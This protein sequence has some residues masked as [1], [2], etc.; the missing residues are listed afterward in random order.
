[1]SLSEGREK[2]KRSRIYAVTGVSLVVILLVTGV[3]ARNG[4]FPRTDPMTGERTGWFGAKLAKNTPSSW[5]PFAMPSP[6]PT[7]QLSKEYIY[8]GSRLLAVEDAGANAAPPSDLAVWRPGT[9]NGVWYVLGGPG[10]AQTYY[11][12]GAPTDIPVPGD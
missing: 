8:A 12:W 2:A 3:M 7:P 11:Q 10:S 5:N 4:W 1:M 9:T 6:T